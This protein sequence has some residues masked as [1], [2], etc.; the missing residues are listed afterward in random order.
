MCVSIRSF[1][2]A[3]KIKNTMLGGP[4]NHAVDARKTFRTVT[5]GR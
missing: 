4:T 5:T 3:K 2:E 1:L